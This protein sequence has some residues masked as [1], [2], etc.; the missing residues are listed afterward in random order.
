[1]SEWINIKENPPREGRQV[2][3]RC[4]GLEG[5]YTFIGYKEK[6]V[7]STINIRGGW[8]YT[9]AEYI[10]HWMPL[11]DNPGKNV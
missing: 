6:D 4:S 1:M 9:P 3:C 2:V 10:T 5:T 8:D 7:F 11:P